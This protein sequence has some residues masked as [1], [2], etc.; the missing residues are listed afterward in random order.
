MGTC[1]R[2]LLRPMRLVYSTLLL[3]GVRGVRASQCAQ[4][5]AARQHPR[6]AMERRQRVLLGGFARNE[7]V[8]VWASQRGARSR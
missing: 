8:C 3:R 1:A 4:S 5:A 2:H 7:G 6:H